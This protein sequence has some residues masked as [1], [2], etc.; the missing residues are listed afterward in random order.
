MN[1]F[2]LA[3]LALLSGLAVQATPASARM[4]GVSD[5]EIGSVDC[6]RI[7]PK[8]IAT[9]GGGTAIPRQ[10]RQA[11]PEP[12]VRPLFPRVYIPSVQFGPDRAFE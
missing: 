3:L 2:I 4:C 5:T 11:R 10:S 12:R 9:Q 7:S 6:T 8:A 1:R